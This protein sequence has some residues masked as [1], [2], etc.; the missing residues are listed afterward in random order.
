MTSSP[1]F[2]PAAET[3]TPP[4]TS[5]PAAPRPSPPGP[6]SP[7]LRWRHN[8]S[9]RQASF[10]SSHFPSICRSQVDGAPDQSWRIQVDE[11]NRDADRY[12]PRDQH[13]GSISDLA[14]HW[15]RY[16]RD[17]PARY[18]LQPAL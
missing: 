3:T 1:T 16:D 18:H 4:P 9:Y 13:P 14:V 12:F 6:M 10:S 7:A 11:P 2:S 17:G 8:H 15:P 5:G